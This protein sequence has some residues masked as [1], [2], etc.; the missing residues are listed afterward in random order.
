[1]SFQVKVGDLLFSA[2]QGDLR[3]LRNCIRNRRTNAAAATS[4]LHLI[5]SHRQTSGYQRISANSNNNGHDDG[6]LNFS[7]ADGWTALHFS[8]DRTDGAGE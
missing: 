7:N 2:R 8:A 5:T 3:Q 4:P 6:D 1:M